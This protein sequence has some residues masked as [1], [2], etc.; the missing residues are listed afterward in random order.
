MIR[1]LENKNNLFQYREKWEGE[2]TPGRYI[3]CRDFRFITHYIPKK[4]FAE[5]FGGYCIWRIQ[6]K[7]YL[8]ENS[9]LG[10]YG[11]R[12]A[13]RLR[14]LLKERGAEFSVIDCPQP[15]SRLKSITKDHRPK[16]RKLGLIK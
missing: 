12:N 14:R 16:L 4:E 1:G 3:T 6:N 2:A 8:P 10:V 7:W 13:N 9:S 11:K 5:L 15:K